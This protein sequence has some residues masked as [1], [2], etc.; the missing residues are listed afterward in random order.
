MH[1]VHNQSIALPYSFIPCYELF[2]MGAKKN[3]KFW[4]PASQFELSDETR[5]DSIQMSESVIQF[6]FAVSSK[7]Q[8]KTGFH[9]L[10]HASLV[11]TILPT[12]SPSNLLT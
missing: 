7:K 9:D 1:I 2:W 5:S 3:N 12:F 6:S 10:Q 11:S 4:C 8:N